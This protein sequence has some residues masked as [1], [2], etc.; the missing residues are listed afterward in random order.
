MLGLIV[1]YIWAIVGFYFLDDMFTLGV[2][3]VNGDELTENQCTTLLQ[4][5]V[6]VVNHGLIMGGGIADLMSQEVFTNDNAA[7]YGVRYVYDLAFFMIIKMAF[8]NIIFGIIIDTFA[9]LRDKRNTM[10]EDMKN[11]CFICGIE[12]DEFDQFAD[13]FEKHIE[14]DHHLW[15]YL[16][17][18]YHLNITDETEYNGIESYVADKVKILIIR[19]IVLMIKV[20]SPY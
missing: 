8:L 12:R 6:V 1:M 9:D 4:C 7:R 18:L 14:R 16:F 3:D 15:N 13:G 2:Y 11:V 17:Y 10:E 20:G 5:F 19:S